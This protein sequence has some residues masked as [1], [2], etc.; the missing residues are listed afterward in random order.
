MTPGLPLGEIYVGTV[1]SA[2]LLL[3]LRNSRELGHDSVA[4]RLGKSAHHRIDRYMI[5]DRE[6]AAERPEEARSE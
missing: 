3:A 1:V 6:G 4:R 2:N 5:G